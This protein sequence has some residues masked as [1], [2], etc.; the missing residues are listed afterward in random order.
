MSIF[1]GKHKTV[2]E[3]QLNLRPLEQELAEKMA[4]ATI[5]E[6]LDRYIDEMAAKEDWL[7]SCQSYYDSRRR[8][9]KINE[10]Q[11]TIEWAETLTQTLTS[12]ERA[13]MI[14]VDKK[15]GFRFTDYGYKPLHNH[16]NELGNEDVTI[17]QI[18]FLWGIIVRDRMKARLP[19][20]RFGKV[21]Q[22]LGGTTF[23]YS[24][25]EK[26]WKDWF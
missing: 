16:E 17:D 18:M 13:T 14:D 9:V 20:C 24:V 22:N 15:L 2:E 11:F 6:D 12:G 8:T 19:Q 26:N 23:T 21:F 3:E 7:V 10:D 25:P 1:D 4:K 5:L